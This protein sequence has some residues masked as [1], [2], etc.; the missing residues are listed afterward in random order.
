MEPAS[1]IVLLG[2]SKPVTVAIKK[3]DVERVTSLPFRVAVRKKARAGNANGDKKVVKQPAGTKKGIRGSKTS[4]AKGSPA[5]RPQKSSVSL[6]SLSVPLCTGKYSREEFQKQQRED[7]SLTPTIKF[8]TDGTLPTDQNELS[9]VYSMAS[10]HV[11]HD[12]LL[13][14][15]FPPLN[16]H[17]KGFR[18]L[19]VVPKALR[20][21][22]L[23]DHHE[24]LCAG[25]V[26]VRH[27][28]SKVTAKFFWPSV[29]A[30]VENYV[31]S[32]EGCQKRKLTYK[33]EHPMVI[34]VTTEPLTAFAIDAVGP[35]LVSEGKRFIILVMDIASYYV[36][37]LAIPNL[38]ATTI[39][40][41]L[42]EN[43]IFVF[44]SPVTLLSDQKSYFLDPIVQAVADLVGTDRACI[45]TYNPK[46]NGKLERIHKEVKQILAAYIDK[47]QH[48]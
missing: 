30:N 27:T 42:V 20:A 1:G 40:R 39:A 15:L 4:P 32:C 2:I 45:T 36:I 5:A 43:V 23:A 28:L 48:A 17:T 31:K 44:G 19:T 3:S 7:S 33:K 11:L 18:A 41:L 46:A 29:S 24:N 26:G 8:L 47:N 35:L 34:P 16:R 21:E 9:T 38:K 12:G 37:L 22:I 25:H 13:V 14:R 10:A 6:P